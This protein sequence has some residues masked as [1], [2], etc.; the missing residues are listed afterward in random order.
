MIINDELY[1]RCE[2]NELSV[3]R[4]YPSFFWKG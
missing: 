1:E 3:V 4:Y 2:R